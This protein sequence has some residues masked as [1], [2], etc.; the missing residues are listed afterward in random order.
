MGKAGTLRVEAANMPKIVR[1]KPAGK[2]RP[3]P[4]KALEALHALWK[5]DLPERFRGMTE[6]QVIQE[7]K[8]TREEIWQEKLASRP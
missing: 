6:A 8:K 1:D 4:K 7:I 3:D 2:R 5:C